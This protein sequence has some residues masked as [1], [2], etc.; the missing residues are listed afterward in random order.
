MTDMKKTVSYALLLCGLAGCSSSEYRTVAPTPTLTISAQEADCQVG[1]TVSVTLSVSQEGVDGGFELS[2]FIR[3]GA[4]SVTLNDDPIGTAGQWVALTGTD[5]RI[6]VSPQEAGLLAVSFQAKAP[7]GK[8]SEALE[9]HVSVSPASRIS[10]EA[11]CDDRIVNPGRDDKIPVTLRIDGEAGR[12]TVVPSLSLGNGVIYCDG[13]IV[14][15][16]ECAAEAET[17]F[18]YE[19]AVIGEHILEFDIA[20]AETSV[21]AR[22]YMDIVKKISVKSPLE[23]CFTFRGVGEHDM[24]GETVTL[25]LVNEDLFNFEVAGWYDA[26]GRLISADAT[27]PLE[28]NLYSLTDFEVKLKTR[29]VNISRDGTQTVEFTYLIQQNGKPVAKK[30]YDYRTQYIAD[31]KV[32]EPITFRYEEYRLDKGKIPPQKVKTQ[33]APIIP[34][35]AT[36]S[37]YL[38][39]CDKK[40]SVYLREK[41]NPG[42]KFNY[43]RKYIE[44]ETTKYYIPDDVKM[45]Q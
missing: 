14:N 10:A 36:R 30:A 25:E 16:T 33:G 11:L 35:G 39:R 7:D 15:D 23:G 4:A 43:A 26:E 21:K 20:T 8:T 24:Q 40:F 41:D 28:M 45:Q 18:Y 17:V 44:S 6:T 1:K 13:H 34:E 37:T 5:A 42:F 27:C 31:Y 19:P 38:W 29:T 3:Q 22:A 32:S 2:T 12:Y 9:L